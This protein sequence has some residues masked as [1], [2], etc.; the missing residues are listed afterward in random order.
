MLAALRPA[1]EPGLEA[2]TAP[3]GDACVGPLCRTARE[4]VQGLQ[5]RGALDLLVH[6][7]RVR[8]EAH[9]PGLG[10][11][12]AGAEGAPVD[13]SHAGRLPGSSRGVRGRLAEGGDAPGSPD[14]AG[15]R[16]ARLAHCAK[17]GSAGVAPP[18][19]DAPLA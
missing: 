17:V 12:A 6:L 4:A 15:G 1:E 10:G 19:D 2:R 3:N 7:G 16:Q 11:V 8:H 5:H 9:D 18:A 13:V 14:R